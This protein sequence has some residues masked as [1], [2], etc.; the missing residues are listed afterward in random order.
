MK[1]FEK[2]RDNDMPT[3]EKVVEFTVVADC[4]AIPIHDLTVKD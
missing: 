4:K 2:T 1:W 3:D